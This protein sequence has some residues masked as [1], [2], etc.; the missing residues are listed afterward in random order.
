MSPLSRHLNETG[1][2]NASF[3]NPK[4]IQCKRF[5]STKADFTLSLMIK[6]PAKF[7]IQRP[8]KNRLVVSLCFMHIIMNH[9]H[10]CNESESGKYSGLKRLQNSCITTCLCQESVVYYVVDMVWKLLHKL[11]LMHLWHI[12]IHCIQWRSSDPQGHRLFV[13]SLTSVRRTKRK[14]PISEGTR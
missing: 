13:S 8:I 4:L 2:H 7:V 9:G 3:R 14:Q 1:I 11:I 12:I 5:I 6:N 10:L